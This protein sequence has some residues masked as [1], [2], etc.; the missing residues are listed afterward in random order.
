LSAQVNVY[1]DPAG[2]VFVSTHVTIQAAIDA[3]TTMD[4]YV[5][6]VDAGSYPEMIMVDKSLILRGAKGL[7]KNKISI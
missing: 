1:S 6:R 2:T 7:L 4:G 3:G 5:V